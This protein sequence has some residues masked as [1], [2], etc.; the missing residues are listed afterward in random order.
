MS[1]KLGRGR[2]GPPVLREVRG[3]RT[4]ADRSS[5]YARGRG[6]GMLHIFGK[7]LKPYW[8]SNN[9]GLGSKHPVV[10]NFQTLK[11]FRE[12]WPPQARF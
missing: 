2:G 3:F 4:S 7:P 8:L 6:G 10:Q 11:I 1:E 12:F 9:T 5:S